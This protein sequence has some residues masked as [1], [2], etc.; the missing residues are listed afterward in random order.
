MSYLRGLNSICASNSRGKRHHFFTA[1]HKLA[2]TCEYD[3]FWEDLIRDSLI[4]DISGVKLFEKLQ[5]MADLT[6][7]K[8]ITTVRQ[9]EQV[10]QQQRIVRGLAQVTFS[11]WRRRHSK[12]TQA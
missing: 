10:H 9:A 7:E 8:N 11:C 5:M 3:A 1:I 12:R 6:L 2:E 4:V